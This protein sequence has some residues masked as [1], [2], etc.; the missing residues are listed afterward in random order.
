MFRYIR[1]SKSNGCWNLILIILK[2]SDLL[3]CQF[4]RYISLSDTLDVNLQYDNFD[5][6]VYLQGIVIQ[7]SHRK[8]ITYPIICSSFIPLNPPHYELF[9]S[10]E[11]RNC[12][13]KL[14]LC[15]PQKY[16]KTQSE[17]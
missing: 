2:S 13:Q 12:N 16:T 17:F 1:S 5:Y 9:S 7:S 10:E 6:Y 3:E 11:L 8:M 4:L 15:P 14:F